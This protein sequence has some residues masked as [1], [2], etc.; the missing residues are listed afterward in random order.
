MLVKRA[1]PKEIPEELYHTILDNFLQYYEIHK[2]DKTAPYAGIEDTLKQLQQK[3]ILM[4]VATNKPHVLL[5][6]LMRYYFPTIQWAAVFGNRKEVPVKPNPQIVYD[7]LKIINHNRDNMHIISIDE[8]L[9][10]GDTAVDMETAQNAGVKKVGVLWGFRTKEEL[11][12][13]NADYIIENPKELIN[14]IQKKS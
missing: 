14:L 13:A 3:K 7:I 11:V 1:L 9:Y 4:A 2:S 12:R 5:P 10:V 8:V 6:D